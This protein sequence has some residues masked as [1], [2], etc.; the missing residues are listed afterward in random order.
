[1]A[2]GRGKLTLRAV[3]IAGQ[4]VADVRYVALTR[5]R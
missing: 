2:K 4:A 5:R 3:E 1:L